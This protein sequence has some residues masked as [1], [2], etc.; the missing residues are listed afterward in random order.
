[1]HKML[2]V[3]KMQEVCNKVGQS[4]QWLKK[5]K[6]DVPGFVLTIPGS[7]DHTERGSCSRMSK[8]WTDQ[9]NQSSLELIKSEVIMTIVA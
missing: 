8:K 5:Q 4:F 9:I 3:W 1:V 2:T 6:T 7:N